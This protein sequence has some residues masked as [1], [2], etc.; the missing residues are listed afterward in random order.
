VSLSGSATNKSIP[1][2][3]GE[4]IIPHQTAPCHA[5]QLN[6]CCC[7]YVNQASTLTKRSS[8]TSSFTTGAKGHDS[9]ERSPKTSTRNNGS[10]VLRWK[11]DT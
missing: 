7:D 2:G 10:G 3:E 11:A 8:K 6:D 9:I 5:R 1:Y 4:A